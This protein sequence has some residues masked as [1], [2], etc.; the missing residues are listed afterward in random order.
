MAYFIGNPKSR[1]GKTGIDNRVARN[2]RET[3]VNGKRGGLGAINTTG[4]LNQ[5]D[6]GIDSGV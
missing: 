6:W 1:G 2:M 4:A 3:R 5:G